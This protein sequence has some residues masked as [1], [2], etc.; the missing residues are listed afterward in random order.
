MTHAKRWHAG[1]TG[2][3]VILATVV[4]LSGCRSTGDEGGAGMSAGLRARR[5]KPAVRRVRCLYDQRPW[6]NLDAA[7]DRAPEG[8]QFRVFLDPGNG[9]GIHTEGTFHIE[10]YRIEH[11]VDGE[12]VRTLISDWHYSTD[13]VH[14]IAIPSEVFG[15]GYHLHLLWARKDTAGSDVEIIIR[16]EDPYGNSVRSGTKP[17]S[18]PKHT[19]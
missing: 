13:Q 17:F 3:M 4:G 10:M 15:E 9:R 18:V 12:E 1:R 8:I 2:W 19:S 11:R 14:Q 16:F 7:G 5:Q 6:L